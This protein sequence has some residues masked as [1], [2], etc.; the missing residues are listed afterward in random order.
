[1]KIGKELQK[2]AGDYTKRM[3]ALNAG[4]LERSAEAANKREAL[5][6]K[7]HAKLT[8]PALK[9]P[10]KPESPLAKALM[11]TSVKRGNEALTATEKAEDAKRVLRGFKSPDAV[12]RASLRKKGG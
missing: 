10:G 6:G 12:T 11:T 5:V 7:L 2:M 8:S 4:G 3:M 1:M 9:T